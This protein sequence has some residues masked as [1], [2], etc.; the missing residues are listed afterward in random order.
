[1]K[2]LCH[3][4]GLTIKSRK[5]FVFVLSCPTYVLSCL[6]LP[7]LIPLRASHP[8]Y[9][10]SVSAG[11]G[12]NRHGDQKKRD[13]DPAALVVREPENAHRLGLQLSRGTSYVTCRVALMSLFH[14]YGRSRLRNEHRLRLGL[15]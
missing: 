10:Q 5:S 7:V 2:Q 12:K 4:T 6:S 9:F 1:M 15:R 13:R 11:H 8:D 3:K 14:L